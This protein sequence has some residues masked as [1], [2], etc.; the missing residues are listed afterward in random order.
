MAAAPRPG[1]LPPSRSR[2]KPVAPPRTP[3]GQ[4][5][6]RAVSN[7]G[8]SLDFPW[9]GTWTWRRCT[10]WAGTRGSPPWRPSRSSNGPIAASL[11]VGKALADN[12]HSRVLVEFGEALEESG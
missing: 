7:N 8:V 5:A 12:H 4:A 3:A 1:S 10:T 11:A 9:W 6:R 2:Q